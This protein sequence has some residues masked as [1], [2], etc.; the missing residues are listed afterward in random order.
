MK[1][2]L[3]TTAAVAVLAAGAGYYTGHKQS[4][5]AS[6][7]T[8]MP[9]RKVL[10]WY[11]PMMPG[12]RF[13]KPGKSPFMDM[14]LVPR[15]A[16]ETPADNSVSI[17]A[18]QQQNLG[19]KVAK[20]E[21]RRL[22]TTFSAFATV[23]TDERS[24]QLIP[25]PASGVVEKLFV[26]APQQW[27]KAGEPLAQLWIPDWTAAQQE[28]LAVRQLGDAALTRAARE[29]LALQFMPE[30]VIRLLER[31][32][33]PQTRITLRAENAGYVAKLDTRE[34]AQVVATAPL[35]ELARLDPVWVVIDYPQSQ[36]QLLTPGSE[37]VATSDSWPG[38]T[39]S[40]QVSEL[41][42][43][44]EATTRTLKA[45]I[46]LKNPQQKLKPGM[47]L[48]VTRPAADD[49]SPVLAV[50]EEALID[51]GS[52]SRVIVATGNGHFRAVNVT[53]GITA[54]G[55]TEIQSG[56]QEGDDVVTSGQFLI[57]S[58]ASLRSALPEQTAEKPA[59]KSYE[60]TGVITA[61]D[62]TTITLAH[63]PIPALNWGAMTMDFTLA[64][65][66][67]GVAVGDKV[68]F[69]FTLDDEKGAVI[70]H[71]M[72]AGEGMK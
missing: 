25:S 22:Q 34:G 68:M 50:P 40:G 18:Q 55:W 23:T 49:R 37:I 12:Q 69:Q 2:W 52:N 41:L 30:P 1:K 61:L 11:D 58:E 65:P 59:V 36:A 48:T 17:S 63:E 51:T 38:E 56:L 21:I 45:R 46:V 32:G 14:D 24:V 4:T 20:A 31:T 15:Y 71:L 27:V 54:E 29:R 19:M 8:S 57:D 64:S 66:P 62:G 5:A 33:K 28:Y 72:P 35:F 47:F 43:Q 44:L 3:F 70:T 6:P 39:F 26:R 42:P 67:S 7:T 10:Y 16:D 60:T 9:E 53:R 13:D